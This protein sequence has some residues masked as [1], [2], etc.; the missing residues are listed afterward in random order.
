MITRLFIVAALIGL[1]PSG[2]NGQN[3]GNESSGFVA[4]LPS[5]DQSSPRVKFLVELLPTNAK[6][7]RGRLLDNRGQP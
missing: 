6:P 1:F 2:A 5:Q 3:Q 4:K 7:G